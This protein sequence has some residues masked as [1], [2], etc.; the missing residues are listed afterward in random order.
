MNT[1]ILTLKADIAADLKAIGQLYVAIDR[2]GTVPTGDEQLIVVAYYLHNLYCAFES[3]FQ[4]VAEVFENQL[5]DRAGWHAELLRRMA[6][7]IE[8]IR[9]RLLSE[10]AA[11]CLD[12]LRRFRHLFRSAYRLHLDAERLTLV[13][14][15]A[16]ALKPLYPAD[17]ERF[18]MFLDG[19][20][21]PDE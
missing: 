13:Y 17:I 7:D 3:I 19:L 20:L 9:P 15:K 8:A 5:S 6:L 10:D 4:R 11:D 2:Y 12:E 18:L 1:R 21:Q 14:R 16:Q